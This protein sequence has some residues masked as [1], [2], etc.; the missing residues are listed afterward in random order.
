MIKINFYI[1]FLLFFSKSI[2]SQEPF[3]QEGN[4][5]DLVLRQELENVKSGL[6]TTA[7]KSD[8]LYVLFYFKEFNKIQK[9]P[10]A[11]LKSDEKFHIKGSEWMVFMNKGGLLSSSLADLVEYKGLA[12]DEFVIIQSMFLGKH[13]VLNELPKNICSL[14]RV[15]YYRRN[16][17]VYRVEYIDKKF[18]DE[19]CKVLK[20]LYS[21]GDF[22]KW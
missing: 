5:R 2:F 9:F 15:L 7:V 8:T 20:W 10:I 12:E 22:Y 18:D 3:L 16:K 13:I 19:E 1:L 6:L 17:G 14:N 11:N 21:E 4:F